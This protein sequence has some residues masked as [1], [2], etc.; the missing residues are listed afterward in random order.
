MPTAPQCSSTRRRAWAMRRALA[1]ARAT[2]ASAC[3]VRTLERARTRSNAREFATDSEH[4]E[5]ALATYRGAL[6]RARRLPDP[7][8]RHYWRER[9]ASVFRR[10]RDETSAKRTRASL[11]EATRWTRRL[12]NALADDDDYRAILELAYGMRG[13]FKHLVKACEEACGEGGTTRTRR[14]ERFSLPPLDAETGETFTLRYL[15]RAIE[16]RTVD[17]GAVRNVDDGLSRQ[18][19]MLRLRTPRYF[20]PNGCAARATN[21]SLDERDESAAK[22]VRVWPWEAATSDDLAV[23]APSYGIG[24]MPPP[25]D[26]EMIHLALLKTTFIPLMRER[27]PSMDRRIRRVYERTLNLERDCL[28]IDDVPGVF[29]EDFRK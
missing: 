21:E 6:R 29:L 12:R 7:C 13:R 4:R 10:R 2:C 28:R 22:Y 8:A 20:H 18:M 16:A 11:A 17:D 27:V 3:A 26:W 24:T 1:G 25:A 23:D 14:V 9:F 19:R 5:R 15:F